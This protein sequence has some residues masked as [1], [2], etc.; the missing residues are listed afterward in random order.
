MV[1]HEFD[2]VPW[3]RLGL[4]APLSCADRAATSGYKAFNRADDLS[5][6]ST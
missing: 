3:F 6:R 1:S 5:V 2:V 4:Q